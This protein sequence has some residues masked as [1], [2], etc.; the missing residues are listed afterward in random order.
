MSETVFMC[1]RCSCLVHCAEAI[2]PADHLCPQ[3][4]T[5]TPLTPENYCRGWW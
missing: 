5:R 2:V 1:G 4:A 3:C